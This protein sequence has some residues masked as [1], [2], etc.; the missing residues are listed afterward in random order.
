M[1]NDIFAAWHFQN[2]WYFEYLNKPLIF[3]SFNKKAVILIPRNSRNHIFDGIFQTWT[4]SILKIIKALKY[5]FEDILGT[6][7]YKS[8]RTIYKLNS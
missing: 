1:D 7:F 8:C 3:K 4:Y 6:S 2:S 5:D